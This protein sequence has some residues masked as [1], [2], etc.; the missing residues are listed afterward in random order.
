MSGETNH[1]ASSESIYHTYGTGRP[2][3]LTTSIDGDK[4]IL[5]WQ[6]TQSESNPVYR[7]FITVQED[8]YH[9][10]PDYI[11]VDAKERQAALV[12]MNVNANYMLRVR[13]FLERFI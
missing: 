5:S 2:T 1:G 11:S 6:Y 9:L 3:D 7:F 10:P 4:L 12:G 8:K 13:S